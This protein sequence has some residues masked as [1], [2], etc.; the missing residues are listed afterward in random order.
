MGF[1][2]IKNLVASVA[3]ATP[4]QFDSWHESWRAAANSGSMEPLLGFIARER[5]VTED[6]FLQKLAQ[7]LG[8]PYLDLP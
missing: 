4:V 2:P 3:D 7:T 1:S 5:G 6:A 8:W